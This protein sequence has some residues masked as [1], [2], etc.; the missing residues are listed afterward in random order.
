ME[1]NNKI[2]STQTADAAH[3]DYFSVRLLQMPLNNLVCVTTSMKWGGYFRAKAIIDT[4]QRLRL[5]YINIQCIDYTTIQG[6]PRLNKNSLEH[7]WI[8][9]TSCVRE[10]YV[11]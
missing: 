7:I 10:K 5:L 1:F 11:K 8:L 4:C 2:V 6:S 3:T 9:I